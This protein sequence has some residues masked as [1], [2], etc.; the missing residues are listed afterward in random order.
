[1]PTSA[2]GHCRPIRSTAT[3]TASEKKSARLAGRGGC[4]RRLV[5]VVVATI[6]ESSALAERLDPES[7]HGLLDR[8][9][10]TWAAA[11][12]RHGLAHAAAG[13]LERDRVALSPAGPAHQGLHQSREGGGALR[14]VLRR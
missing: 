10:E 4:A 14:R 7:L 9:S 1:M 13:E 2:S 12:E 11:L 8:C 3:R 5:S 6:A